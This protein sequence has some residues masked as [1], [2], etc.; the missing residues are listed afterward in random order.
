MGYIFLFAIGIYILYVIIKYISSHPERKRLRERTEA[1][2]EALNG[3]D[4]HAERERILGLLRE[5]LPAGYQCGRRGCKGILLK[6]PG[7]Y[8]VC[9]KCRNIRQ[10]V[11]LTK[12]SRGLPNE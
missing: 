4:V 8:Y 12:R 10:N 1:I 5:C 7:N 9:S 3:F 2:K 6:Q 11:S